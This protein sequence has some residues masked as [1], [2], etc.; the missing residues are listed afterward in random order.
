MTVLNLRSLMSGR[1]LHLAGYS[2]SQ[3]CSLKTK[4][5]C[6]H[7]LRELPIAG[8]IRSLQDSFQKCC[9]YHCHTHSISAVRS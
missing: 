6:S 8:D 9:D 1:V 3:T 2:R 5:E 7:A 4:E